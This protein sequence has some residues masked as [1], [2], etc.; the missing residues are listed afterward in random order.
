MVRKDSEQIVEGKE[1][2]EKRIDE[3]VG[4]RMKVK[5]RNSESQMEEEIDGGGREMK[6]RDE[7]ER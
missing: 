2:K 7:G 4:G 5:V 3:L 1:R 6:E